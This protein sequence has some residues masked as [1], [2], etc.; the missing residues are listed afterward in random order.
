MKAE[1]ITVGTELLMGQVINSN[2]AY[3]SK[4]LS[5]LGIEIYHQVT[6][7]DNAERLAEAIKVAES[8]VDTIIL[9]GGLGPTE[10]DITKSVV[11]K[12]LGLN[13]VIHEETEEKIIE[14]HRD[15]DF[16]MPE[17]NRLQALILEGSEPLLNDDGLAVGVFLEKDN[18]AYVML[19]GP[20]SELKPMVENY[21]KNRL[22]ELEQENQ[23]LVSRMIRLF[24]LT[25]AQVAEQLD[26]IIKEQS[27]PTIAIYASNGESKVRI[28]AKGKTE[29]ECEKMITEVEEAI[30]AKIGDY[31]YGYG[32]HTLSYVVQSLLF[33]Q[34][35]KITAAESLTGGAFLS[36]IASEQGASSVL[37]G[38]I[39]VYSSEKKHQALG[40]SNETIDTY[41][42]VS[43]ECAVEMAEK[44]L[45]KFDAD[46]AV[47]LTGVAGPHPLEGK[48][49]G[50]VWIGIA[51]KG[52]TTFA[53]HFH[54]KRD[55]DNNRNLAV[56]NAL[57]LVRRS[58]LGLT[59]QEKVFYMNDN[60]ERA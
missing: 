16:K 28:T 59:I 43:A 54:F 47:S 33:E 14:R 38:G 11:S 9:T 19:P 25:E 37:D 23:K 22:I 5:S 6:V 27:N 24:G 50:I 46:I 13:M 34:S 17:N 44:A 32:D 1:I 52:Q 36:C 12:H 29:D 57:N 35:K 31:I 58:L 48:E 30:K 51:H 20:P 55:R 8:R 10:D 21:L 53:K 42:V 60:D 4:E 3:L 41:G 56:L 40:V 7:G 49:A 39:V 15:S 26:S 18:R 45:E 2:A